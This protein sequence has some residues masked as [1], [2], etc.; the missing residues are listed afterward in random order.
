M[1]LYLFVISNVAN[2]LISLTANFE[3]SNVPRLEG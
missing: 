2:F 1:T 3:S